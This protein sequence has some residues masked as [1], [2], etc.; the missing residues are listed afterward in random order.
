MQEENSRKWYRGDE[1][2]KK[3]LQGWRH[4]NEKLL[5]ESHGIYG[6]ILQNAY[7]GL[8]GYVIIIKI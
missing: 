8:E 6:Q 7:R 3:N 1:R 2:E 4:S 5:A